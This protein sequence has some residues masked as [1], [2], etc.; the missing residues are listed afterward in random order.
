MCLGG[1]RE[2]FGLGGIELL[3]VRRVCCDA[4]NQFSSLF[5]GIATTRLQI[6]DMNLDGRKGNAR[7]SV[8]WLPPL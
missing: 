8:D 1:L 7:L 2:F 3:D 4:L 5:P 6:P